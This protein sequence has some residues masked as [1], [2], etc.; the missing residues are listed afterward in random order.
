MNM[1]TFKISLA[2]LLT[3]LLSCSSEDQSGDEG[4]QDTA[5][6]EDSRTP[7]SGE[8]PSSESYRTSSN[9]YESLQYEE[10]G[11][12]E[13]QS[14]TNDGVDDNDNTMAV[15]VGNPK[16]VGP[17]PAPNFKLWLADAPVDDLTAFI[18]NTAAI[19]FIPTDPAVDPETANLALNIDLLQY[20][21][22]ARLLLFEGYLPPGAY[23]EIHLTLQNLPVI[24]LQAGG[25]DLLAVLN[26]PIAPLTISTNTPFNIADGAVSELLWHV[27]LW[28]ALNK[29]N[30]QYI[31]DA[32]YPLLDLSAI[33]DL[34]LTGVDSLGL[35]SICVR[36][37]SLADLPL[38]AG[39]SLVGNSDCPDA[40]GRSA[41]GGTTRTIP[42]LE[43]GP[44]VLDLYITNILFI[45]LPYLIQ[46]D[47]LLTTTIDL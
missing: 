34:L 20:Q 40:E 27:P 44:Y 46:V 22:G 41:A 25:P 31:F 42:F 13:E 26:N 28:K 5:A 47:A 7:K 18:L 4:N 11:A 38:L 12:S 35:F 17:K 1:K 15:D 24:K 9:G 8:Q 23:K 45:R 2:I 32:I 14:D 43:P 6:S 21:E 37:G 39:L 30:G 16:D 36:R 29:V 33:G 19:T 10:E 3:A